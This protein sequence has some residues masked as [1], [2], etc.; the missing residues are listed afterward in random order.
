[1]RLRNQAF[2]LV[3]AL[4]AGLGAASAGYADGDADFARKVARDGQLEIELGNYAAAHAA[5]AEVKRFGRMMV[6]DHSQVN[7]ELQDIARQKGIQVDSKL[8]PEQREQATKLMNLKGADFDR[9]YV[10]AMVEG[11]E[12]AV[13][14]FGKQADQNRSDLDRWAAGTLPKLRDHLAHARELQQKENRA[15]VSRNP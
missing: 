7:K 11:H 9:A 10:N 15:D 2:V 8:T 1:M 4:V 13:E 3:A 12:K 5:N 14:A 6:D